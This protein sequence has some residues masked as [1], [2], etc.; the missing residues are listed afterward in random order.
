MV[1][2]MKTKTIRKIFLSVTIG[3]AALLT[4]TTAHSQGPEFELV[5]TIA[6]ASTRDNPN[7]IPQINAG[8]I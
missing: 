5:S 4:I 7:H 3:F 8:E 6:F 1:T 2:T